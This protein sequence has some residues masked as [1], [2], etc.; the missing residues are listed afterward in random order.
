MH[1]PLLQALVLR[2]VVVR[3]ARPC[4]GIPD[5]LEEA[6]LVGGQNDDVVLHRRARRR[7]LEDQLDRLARRDG[8]LRLLVLHL[9]ALRL[10]RDR[11][12]DLAGG[13]GLFGAGRALRRCR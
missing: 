7:I 8:K 10:K 2:H 9:V 4:T 13:G 12:I 6:V 1:I 5:F 3:G 11:A